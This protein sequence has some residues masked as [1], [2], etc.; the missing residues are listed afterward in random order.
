MS[1]REDDEWKRE[2]D[3]EEKEQEISNLFVVPIS[4]K[5]SDRLLIYKKRDKDKESWD[6]KRDDDEW[7]R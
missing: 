1:E 7:K 5:V 3:R 6:E 2:R 4:K